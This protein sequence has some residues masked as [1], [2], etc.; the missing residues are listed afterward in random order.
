MNKEDFL[1]YNQSEKYVKAIEK[2]YTDLIKRISKLVQLQV[3]DLNKPFRFSDYPLLQEKADE[4][5]KEF[6][7]NISLYIEV[8]KYREHNL[9][10][11]KVGGVI[12][13]QLKVSKLPT[14]IIPPKELSD[15]VWKYTN[16]YKGEIEL[17]LDLGIGKGK[18]ANT[19]AR[20]VKQYL[21]E[22]DKLFRKVR[23][24]HG[25]L[26]LSQYAQEYHSAS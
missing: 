7:K 6:Y 11:K 17:A 14:N 23:D 19:L 15:R 9:G 3:I 4:I 21:N 12:G 20:D 10:I 13:H 25:N 16:Q 5:L 26:V 1:H 2:H 24:K 22:P 8:A 18:S